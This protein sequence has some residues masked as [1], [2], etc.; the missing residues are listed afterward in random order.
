MSYC[1]CTG[2]SDEDRNHTA[3]LTLVLSSQPILPS[4][5]ALLS[6]PPLVQHWISIFLG[7]NAELPE[8]IMLKQQRGWTKIRGVMNAPAL[9]SI[10]KISRVVKPTFPWYFEIY[11][12]NY[13]N[14]GVQSLSAGSILFFS[15]LN[16]CLY[17]RRMVTSL[18]YVN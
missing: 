7:L 13:L 4:V 6:I 18:D 2:V 9:P 15:W 14:V 8:H 16:S 1:L 5:Y 12:E 3:S 10:N 11:M 17:R